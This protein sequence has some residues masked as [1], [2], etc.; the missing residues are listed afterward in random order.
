MKHTL[1]S[2]LLLAALFGLSGC[3]N[4]A[5]A[6]VPDAPAAGTVEGTIRDADFEFTI[7]RAGPPTDPLEG[8]FVLRGQNLH[9]DAELG[10]LVVDLTISNRGEVSHREPIGL[11]FLKLLPVGVT[12]LNPDNGITGD[13]AAIRFAFANDDV[14]WT[15]GET[16]LPRTV[17][18]GVA[19][20]TAVAFIARLDIASTLDGGMIAGEAWHDINEDGIKDLDEP[21]L[22]GVG[23]TLHSIL[24]GEVEPGRPIQYTE[25]DEAGNYAFSYL[26]AG[27][28]AVS[29][30]VA[31]FWC[32]PTTPTT[33]HVLLTE[34]GDGDVTNFVGADFGCVP[35]DIPPP[36]EIGSYVEVSG[37]YHPDPDRVVASRVFVRT[38]G[39]RPD[40][41]TDGDN[42]EEGRLRGPV[43]GLSRDTNVFAVMGTRV[44]YEHAPFPIELRT[45]L[46]AGVRPAG[47]VGILQAVDLAKWEGEHE[48]VH[49]R[50]QEIQRDPA[51]VI[52][53][54]MRVAETWIVV[55]LGASIQ[56]E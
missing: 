12:V 48:Q 55:P 45:R 40:G 50:V 38:C 31:T 21:G 47:N 53:F 28:Y 26:P 15:P 18:F 35:Q 2:V 4:D 37:E 24:D 1:V 13:G 14:L 33:I 22:A 9:Y 46:D 30:T 19:R 17:H 7:H 52:Q 23:V 43:T 11:T 25:T 3:G 39:V 49:G 41:S 27:V 6:P 56:T 34:T 32:R 8:P 16:S 36:V 10:A 51:N 29:N 44:A 20:N 54:R 5:V 42:C